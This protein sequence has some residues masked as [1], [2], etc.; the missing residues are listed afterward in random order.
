M[1][2]VTLLI[3]TLLL[4]TVGHTQDVDELESNYLIQRVRNEL[5]C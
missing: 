2:P 1:K 3:V 4:L 5:I